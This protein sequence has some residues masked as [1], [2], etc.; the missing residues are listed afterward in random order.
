[1]CKDLI[2]I[3]VRITGVCTLDHISGSVGGLKILRLSFTTITR[4]IG[5]SNI[6][7]TGEPNVSVA[8]D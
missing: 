3:L 6:L 4:T 5:Q 2:V 8:E 7:G 1:M